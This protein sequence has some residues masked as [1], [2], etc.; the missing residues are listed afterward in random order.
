MRKFFL[1]FVL[2][3]LVIIKLLI[4][5]Q[6]FSDELD[7]INKQLSD[8][9]SQ[10]T[11]SQ[12]AT[13]PLES[14]LNNLQSQL[15]GIEDRVA[16]IE[17]DL[18]QKKKYIDSGYKD[19]EKNK[20]IFNRSVRNYYIKSYLISPLI[21]F[22][23]SADAG[24]ITRAIVY[25]QKGSD[26]DRDTITNLALKIVDLETQ[27][28]ELI[29]EQEKL[30]SAKVT[31]SSEKD[32]IDKV[33]RGA[34]QY[35]ASLTSQIAE[36]SAK[37]QQ[38]LSQRLASLN[39]PLSAYA[40]LGGGCSSDLTN[41][42]NPGFSPRIGFFSYGVPNR[43]GLNQYGAKGRADAGQNYTQILN[44]YYS[45][46]I[47]SGQSTSTNIHVVGTNEYGQSFDTNWNIED[48]VK[49]V[50]EMPTTWNPEALKAQAIAARS[51]ALAYTNNG[52]GNICPSQSCQVVKQEQNSQAW[53]DAVNATAGQVLTSGGQPIKAWFSST[54]GGYVHSSSDIGWSATSYTKNAQDTTSNVGSF[55]DLQNNAYDKSS[56]WFYC[57]WGSRGNY[58]GTA[59]LQS[60]E[61]ADIVNIILLAKADSSTSEHLYQTDKPNPAG[62]DTW[63]A[64]R[65]RQELQSRGITGYNSVSDIT[66][67]V[68]FG[69]GKTNSVNVNGDAGSHSFD[70]GEFKN[71]FNLRAPANI[72][73]V[74]PLFNIEKQ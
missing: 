28:K 63:D 69:S 29:A 30:A 2:G 23:S 44:A 65:V 18:A 68:D 48:Y 19:L 36:L 50:Y 54:H 25:Q 49:H 8:L 45:A 11:A 24:Y 17:V 27:Q 32:Q 53:V 47:S 7:D 38:I 14:Q 39:I 13:A 51:Y 9:Q 41:G 56:P 20:E 61:V 26:Q 35:Q 22:I 62:T 33:V 4:A 34:K 73:I 67:S 42:K 71:W 46:D 55:S 15:K 21:V 3:L 59:W 5:P 66:V 37:Q 40:G 31:L 16:S 72:Q 43:V 57:D 12:K 74:G 10:L 64:N 60:G 1:L 70:A 52:S 58:G 6:V